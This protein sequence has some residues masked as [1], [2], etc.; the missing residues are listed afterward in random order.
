V[1]KVLLT[2]RLTRDP[3][4]RQL[5]SGKTL[6]AFNVATNEYRGQGEE[7]AEYHSVVTWDRLAE[8]CGEYLGKGSQVAIDG[9]I[10]TRQWEDDRGVRHWKTEIVA[11]HVEMLSGRRKKDYEAKAV[12]DSGEAAADAS[13]PEASVVDAAEPIPDDAAA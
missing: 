10:Q 6:T 8:V 3:E 11:G 5:A 7:R 4:T 9:R 13:D 2:G 12:S 1:N